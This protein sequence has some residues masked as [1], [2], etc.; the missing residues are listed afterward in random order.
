M[1]LGVVV[2]GVDAKGTSTGKSAGAR[3][4][5]CYTVITL[6][7]H[8]S[9]TVVMLLLHYCYTVV[10]LIAEVSR[11]KVHRLFELMRQLILCGVSVR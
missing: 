2:M 1:T 8:C 5:V 10:N 6:L 4:I 3:C 11:G 7:L 9:Y